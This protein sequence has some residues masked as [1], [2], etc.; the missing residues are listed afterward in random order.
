MSNDAQLDSLRLVAR[1]AAL[2]SNLDWQLIVAGAG[3]RWADV[4]GLF[5]GS[6]RRLDRQIV[7][8]TPADLTAI[9]VSGDLFLWPFADDEY[10]LIVL[11][12]QAAGLAVVA[13]RSS[14]MLD[15]VANGETGM[16]VKPN[17]DASFANAVTFLLRQPDFRRTFAR[18]APQWVSANFGINV[19]APLLSD[20]IRR[21]SNEYR[22]RQ[23]QTPA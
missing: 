21:I 16:L 12:A 4:D 9:L 23:P 1:T 19:V 14:A 8:A 5:R 2:A 11:E 17:N 10:S 13:P 18:K 20:A 22:S 15:I 7:I 6:P 3:S